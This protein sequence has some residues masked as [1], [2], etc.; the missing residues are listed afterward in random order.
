MPYLSIAT[1]SIPI[2]NAN[3]WYTS[4]SN[5]HISKTRGLT[6]PA[7][8]ISIHPVCLHIGQPLPPQL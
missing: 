4:E 5:P 8:K 1:R 3:P 2:P 6:I 7:P